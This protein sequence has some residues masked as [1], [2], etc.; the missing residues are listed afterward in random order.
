MKDI[1][2]DELKTMR[3]REGL[4]IQGCGGDPQ[5]WI[6]GIQN[7]LT[8]EEILLDGD[9]FK[10]V[11]RFENEGVT[12]LLFDFRDTKLNVGKLAAWRLSTHESFGGTW[13]S[14]YLD[15][16]FGKE[17]QTG[18]QK[19]DCPLIGQDGNVFGLVGIAARTLR[20]NGMRK[21]ATEMTKRIT[22]CD[23]YSEALGIIG[24]YVNITSVDENE[25]E[26][27]DEDWEEGED[28]EYDEDEGLFL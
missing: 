14:D 23:S 20:E 15:N 3:N 13:L 7:L 11:F 19:P 9:I 22:S 2:L 6:D 1:T 21:E 16:R 25:D 24:E 4:I 5:E 12:C 10:D 28:E 18:R 8:T 27:E 26:D 17:T